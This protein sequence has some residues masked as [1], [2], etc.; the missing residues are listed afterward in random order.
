MIKEDILERFLKIIFLKIKILSTGVYLV[1]KKIP[2][3]GHVGLLPQ[4]SKNFKVKGKNELQKVKILNDA[5][6]Q[7]I[8]Q[9]N[10]KSLVLV[11]KN[12]HPGII[13][14]VASKIVD[15]L[16]ILENDGLPSFH[17]DVR[18]TTSLKI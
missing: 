11:S 17:L 12:W 14:I 4:P 6:E 7:A 5:R 15:E 2:I 16:T 3:M 13:G 9:G 18:F 8:S 10:K 1:K